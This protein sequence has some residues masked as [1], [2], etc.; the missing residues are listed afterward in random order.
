MS[1]IVIISP[2]DAD[3]TDAVKVLKS[4]G[5]DVEV[6]EPTAKTLLHILLGL[7][8]PGAFG[9]GPEYVVAGGKIDKSEKSEK[10]EEKEETP[11]DGGGDGGG[12]GGDGGGDDFSFE[13]L[14]VCTVDG[15][16]VEAVRTN[17]AMSKLVVQELVNGAKTTYKINEST[18]SFWPIDP[19]APAQRVL[20]EHQKH[21]AALDIAVQQG[22]TGK[23]VLYVGQD[24]IDVFTTK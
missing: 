12:D 17:D 24:L 1:K 23:T 16:L 18:F 15:E 13:S 19:Q 10:G 21:R 5:H 3:I 7:F 22:S 9:F 8:S 14:G 6:E 11:E 20:I 2:K 4:S